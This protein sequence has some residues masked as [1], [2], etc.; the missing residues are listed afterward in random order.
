MEHVFAF[1]AGCQA[2]QSWNGWLYMA[3]KVPPWAE[4]LASKGTCFE[5]IVED[6][7]DSCHTTYE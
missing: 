5:G 7:Q 3:D 6:A 2:D 4:R 1:L